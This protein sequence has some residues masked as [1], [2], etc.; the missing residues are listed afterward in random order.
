MEEKKAR[1]R[2]TSKM[3]EIIENNQQEESFVET[4]KADW[5]LFWHGIIGDED[6]KETQDEIAKTKLESLTLEQ[7]KKI[8]KSLSQDRKILNQRIEE[9]NKELDLNSEKIE[10]LKL[11]GG[12]L[13][14]TVEHINRLNDIGQQLTTQLDKLN[15]QLKFFR[16]REDFLKSEKDETKN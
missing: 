16:I 7:I 5:N 1:K 14:E 8:T 2:I 11:V 15:N 9:V 4:I 13:E 10:S 6:N 12:E 3:P